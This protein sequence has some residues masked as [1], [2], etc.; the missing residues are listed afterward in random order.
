MTHKK[1]AMPDINPWYNI[2]LEDYER[3]MSHYMV[4]QAALL[5]RLTKKYLDEIK[6]V[7][8]IFLGISGGN[9]LEH[10]DNSI[11]K[12]VYGIDINPEY[13]NTAN[14]RYGDSIGSLRLL[15]LDIVKH[16]ETICQAD[17]IWAALILEYTGVD[18]VLEFSNNNLHKDGHLVVSIQSNNSQQTVTN[19]GIETI[20][21]A[22]ELFSL[23]DP[24]NLLSKAAENGYRLIANEENIL[25]GRKSIKSFHFMPVS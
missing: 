25:P 24:E 22:G 16:S 13:L 8:A 12:T 2:P 9:G 23:V 17:F 20:K 18:K 14:K 4:G 15:N 7:T 21:K 6:P 11:T 5:N 10:I 19:T 1:S 3:H